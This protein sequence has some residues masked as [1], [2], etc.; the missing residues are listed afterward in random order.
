MLSSCW[1]KVLRVAVGSLGDEAVG[2][3]FKE[4]S[5]VS[6]LTSTS[7]PWVGV[8][9]LPSEGLPRRFPPPAHECWR[10]LASEKGMNS[11]C[12]SFLLPGL[13]LLASVS[14]PLRIQP[15]LSSTVVGMMK[16]KGIGVVQ[17]LL[18]GV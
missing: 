6:N 1:P 18:G 4:D 14:L 17:P 2:R 11:P 8:A 16:E 12:P 3:V 13:R 9:N 7:D 5:R 15:V 10:A